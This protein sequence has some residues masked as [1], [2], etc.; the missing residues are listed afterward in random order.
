MDFSENTEI[1]RDDYVHPSLWFKDHW[2]TLAFAETQMVDFGFRVKFEPRMRQKRRTFRVLLE[3]LTGGQ[4]NI[5][6]GMP[7]SPE[8]GTRLNNGTYLPWHDDWD[9]LADMAKYGL[10]ERGEE[11]L[12]PGRKVKLTKLGRE[13]V[14]RLREHKQNGGSFGNFPTPP[15]LLRVTE[16]SA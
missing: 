14:N 3:Q 13:I 12:E 11:A 16:A 6:N 1:S 5:V 9:C 2:S 8:Y 10:F 15:E 7:M 4:N